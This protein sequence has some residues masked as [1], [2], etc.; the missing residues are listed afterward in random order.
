MLD[1]RTIVLADGYALS[2]FA[3]PP[4]YLDFALRPSIR[5]HGWDSWLGFDGQFPPGRPISRA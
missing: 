4:D 3:L 2:H 5:P 1:R